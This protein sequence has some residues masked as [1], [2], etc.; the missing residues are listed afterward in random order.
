MLLLIT[1]RYFFT[2]FE[3]IKYFEI[4]NPTL[5]ERIILSKEIYLSILKDLNIIN[6]FSSDL[7]DKVIEYICE[8][9]S[10]NRDL[11]K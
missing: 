3:Q 4:Q 11:K 10:S 6:K 2:Y 7:D 8:H 9:E 1:K 5:K